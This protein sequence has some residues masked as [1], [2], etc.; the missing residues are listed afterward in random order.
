MDRKSLIEAVQT[1]LGIGVDGD[2]G[3]ETW[4][5]IYAHILGQIPATPPLVV[6]APPADSAR[7]DDRSEKAIATLL[8]RVQP[9]A[10]L[11]VIAAARQGITIKVTSALRTYAEQDDLYAQGRTA[12]G[13]PVTNAPAGYSNHNFGLAFDVT[14]FD[15]GH[16]VYESPE[17]KTLGAIGKSMGLTW[18]GD[19]ASID[20]EPHFEL[21][22][23]WAKDMTEGQMLAE[24]RRRKENNTA[25]FP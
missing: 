18:G 7:V 6:V 13:R 1:A 10:R 21:R 17:Y 22:P 20:D 9:C 25:V 12:P 14:I 24:L 16:P 8:P 3:D 15:D 11:L 2:P 5:A 19:W 4:N 23:D